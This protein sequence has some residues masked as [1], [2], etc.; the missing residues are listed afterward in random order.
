MFTELRGIGRQTA[1]NLQK[2]GYETRGDVRAATDEQLASV[3]GVGA[4]SIESLRK[5]V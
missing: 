3:S 5:E 1:E 2:A 4:T